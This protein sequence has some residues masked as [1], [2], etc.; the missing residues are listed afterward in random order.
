MLGTKW[1]MWVRNGRDMKWS[2]YEMTC[3]RNNARLC[4]SQSESRIIMTHTS[5]VIIP[6]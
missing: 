4:S 5:N 2:R 6:H 3:L 1:Q